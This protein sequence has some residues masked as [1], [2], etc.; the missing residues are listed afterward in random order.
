MY[1]EQALSGSI[2][3]SIAIAGFSGIIAVFGQRGSTW[4]TADQ[5]RLRILLTAS[6]MALFF[7]MF[8]FVLLDS[9]IDQRTFWRVGSALQAFWFI[10]IVAYR[11]R[12]ATLAGV[13]EAVGLSTLALVVILLFTLLQIFNAIC[14]A[15]PWLYVVGVM[16]QIF[17]AFSA[18][19]S[20]LLE[21]WDEEDET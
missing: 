1:W 18:F 14:F 8:P 9:G 13:T 19:A 15:L 20:L 11:L 16:F 10:S 12:Q 21:L 2:E 3:V 7:S 6:A 4:Q 17:V 5:L